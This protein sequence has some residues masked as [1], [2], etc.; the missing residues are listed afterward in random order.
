MQSLK[1]GIAGCSWRRQPR[2]WLIAFLA[3]LTLLLAII[4]CALLVGNDRPKFVAGPQ[5]LATVGYG[6]D[7]SMVVD[8][9]GFVYYTVIPSELFLDDLDPG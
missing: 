3:A 8:H 9:S 6:F 7:T 4:L 2:V 1:L 5:V